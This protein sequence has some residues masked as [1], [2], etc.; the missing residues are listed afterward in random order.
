MILFVDDE[1]REVRDYVEE[2]ELSDYVVTFKDDPSEALDFF[3]E[4]L[5]AI[6]L[7]ILDLMMPPGSNF[8]G[9][10]T[11][12]GLRTGVCFY[13]KI[14]KKAPDLWVFILTNVSDDAV[15][16][17]FPNEDKCRFLRKEEVFPIQ[18]VEKVKEVFPNPVSQK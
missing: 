13:E 9:M 3:Y 16:R 12:M 4:N 17:L 7:L 14:R 1:M 11:E 10:N 6:T 8:E 2:L 15:A 5:D 18:L